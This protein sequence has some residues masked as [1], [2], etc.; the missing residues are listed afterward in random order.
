MVSRTQAQ[1]L[2][3]ELEEKLEKLN[4]KRAAIVS[5]VTAGIEAHA[6][7]TLSRAGMPPITITVEATAKQASLVISRDGVHVDA[8]AKSR[9][10][11]CSIAALSAMQ[12]ASNATCPVLVAECA[13]MD[14]DTLGKLLAALKPDK[15]NIILEHHT[16]PDTAPVDV[17]CIRMEK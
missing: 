3:E 12:Q 1:E 5:G 13:E 16:I 7:G 14:M 2:V 4:A 17:V 8:L 10:L 11:V 15:G 9:R 6:N